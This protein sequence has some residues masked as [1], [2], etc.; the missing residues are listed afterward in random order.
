MKEIKKIVADNFAYFRNKNNYSQ[1]QIGE[2][3]GAKKTTVSG[4]EIY[5]S[6]INI[7]KLY[8]ACKVFNIS[9][10]EMFLT[11]EE[12]RKISEKQEIILSDNEKDLIQKYRNSLEIQLRINQIINI[13]IDSSINNQDASSASV[14]EILDLFSKYS[15]L[16]AHGKEVVNTI[17][18]LEFQNSAQKLSTNNQI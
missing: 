1:Q 6:A 3:I 2:L 8:K 11:E 17:I 9:I 13:P 18:N 5:T 16:D 10:N 4:W 14:V 15:Y 12:R 7:E